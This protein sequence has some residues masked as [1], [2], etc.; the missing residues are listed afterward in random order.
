MP[1][2]DQAYVLASFS[3]ANL[4]EEMKTTPEHAT[5]SPSQAYLLFRETRPDLFSDILQANQGNQNNP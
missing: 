2:L 3:Q 1:G 4:C 5:P